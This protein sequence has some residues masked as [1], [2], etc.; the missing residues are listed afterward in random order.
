[1]PI[2]RVQLDGA[3]MIKD[4]YLI[5]PHCHKKI[6]PIGEHD[7]IVTTVYCHNCK[8]YYKIVIADG[9]LMRITP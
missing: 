6:Q 8:R 4:G 2:V 5:C 9:E 3:A 7:T 1:M